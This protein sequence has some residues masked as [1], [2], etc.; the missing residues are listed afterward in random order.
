VQF[1]GLGAPRDDAFKHVGKPGHRLD[2]VQLRRLCRAPNY[3][4]CTVILTG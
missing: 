3:Y 1:V 2:V 4:L